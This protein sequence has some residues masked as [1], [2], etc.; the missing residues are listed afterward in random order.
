MN[1]INNILSPFDITL[2]RKS[3]MA[4]VVR[5][6]ENRLKQ[7]STFYSLS[8]ANHNQHLNKQITGLVFS[9]DRAMQ[10]HALLS[11]YFHYTQNA[12]PLT[13]L[14]TFSSELHQQSYVTLQ[15]QFMHLPVT[16]VQE[17]NFAQQLLQLVKQATS[18]RIFFMTD[19]GI[20]LDHFDLDDC[21]NFDPLKSVF[22]LRLGEDL[23]F[24]YSFNRKQSI[25]SFQQ[26]VI[27]ENTFNKWVW[28]NAES[29][30]DWSYP[31]S[32]DATIFLRAEIE[33]MLDFTSFKSPNSLES[34]LQLFNDLFLY[35]EGVCYSKVKY[36]NVP[37][38]LV[39]DEYLNHFTGT[40]SA[41]ELLTLFQEGS[42]IDWSVL[43]KWNARDAQLA[44]FNFINEQPG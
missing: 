21:L 37:C 18:D 44:R 4:K 22:S 13:V 40:Y 2:G 10:L 35:R 19:D 41:S 20:F 38:N 36:V 24:C 5:D 6:F 8:L 39:Q 29:S 27:K 26:E 1:I 42:R 34:Q 16:F 3:A 15:N 25:P 31:L 11:S 30:P 28:K 17:V 23:D 7:V 33:A 14:F 9:K 32:V 12:A 43:E